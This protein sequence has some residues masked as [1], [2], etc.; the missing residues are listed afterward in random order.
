M[1]ALLIVNY[2]VTDR[3]A[4]AG[5]RDAAAPLLVGPGLSEAVAVS[6]ETID[7]REGTSAGTDTVVLKFDSVEAAR[8]A[9]SSDA[10][11]AIINQRLDATEP[12]IAFIVETLG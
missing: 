10:Y 1:P 5:Y 12:K 6:S 2:D 11:Q 3:D 9:F 7:L 8:R 4:L